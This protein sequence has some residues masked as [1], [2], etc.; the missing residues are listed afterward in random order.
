[1]PARNLLYPVVVVAH[2]RSLG[3]RK[4]DSRRESA[5]PDFL[6]MAVGICQQEKQ[7]AARARKQRMLEMEV[8]AKKR[9]LKSDIEVGTAALSCQRPSSCRRSYCITLHSFANEETS[10]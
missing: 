6:H 4:F 10:S 9:A 3:N 1:M 8:E 5:S 7:R 2:G